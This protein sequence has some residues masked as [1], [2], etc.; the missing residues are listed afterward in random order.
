MPF[1]EPIFFLAFVFADALEQPAFTPAFTAP[2]LVWLV[3]A[4]DTNITSVLE[5]ESI[6]FFLAFVFAD[7]LEQP[8]FTPA[9]TTTKLVWLV[10]AF[11][12]D[13]TTILVVESIVFRIAH[14]KGISITS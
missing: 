8:A 7:A 9:F 11:D 2:K 5:V 10:P 3:P 14:F 1:I 13:I 4:F 6:V 12:T